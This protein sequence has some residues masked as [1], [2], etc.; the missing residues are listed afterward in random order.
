MVRASMKLAP[1]PS[2]LWVGGIDRVTR[3]GIGLEQIC[4]VDGIL[5]HQVLDEGQRRERDRFG[6]FPA[7]DALNVAADTFELGRRIGSL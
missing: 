4:A 6:D 2:W 3:D 1:D 5:S 7:L